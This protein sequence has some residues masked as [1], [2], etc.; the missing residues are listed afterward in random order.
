MA[1][2]RSKV[3]QNLPKNLYAA[4][5]KGVIYYT[6]KSPVDGKR[7][8]F[9]TDRQLAIAAANEINQHYSTAAA[10]VTRVM[11]SDTGIGDYIDHYKI[12]ILPK[13]RIKGQPLSRV[14]LDTYGWRL[15]LIKKALGS[16]SFKNTP[17]RVIAE[18]LNKQ[19]TAEVYNKHRSQLVLL[20]RHAVSDGIVPENYPEK[21][22]KR[23][24]E[25]KLRQRLTLDGYKAIYG[26]AKPSI[27][28][29][30]EIGLNFLHRRAD[31]QS[32]RF[33]DLKD[34]NIFRIVTKS[35]KHGSR[36]HLKIPADMPAIHSERGSTTLKGLIQS[37]RD[38]VLCPYLVHEKPKRY[39][40]SKEKAHHFQLSKS[41][42]SDGFAKARDGSGF[43]DD[44]PIDQRPTLHEVISLGEYLMKEAGWSLKFIQTLRGHANE[45]TTLSYLE[46]HDKW[47]ELALPEAEK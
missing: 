15:D 33:D 17:Q 8:G 45:A 44:M 41:Q 31:I 14:T 11:T 1:R 39:R 21:I 46:G 20:Y 27:Q 18:Y 34:G 36:A 28:S 4:I 13:R 26:H 5:T 37:C 3:N 35:E 47:T 40:P 24:N 43:Y 22:I 6:Y 19:A 7:K 42:L 38:D 12:N 2:P 16:R 30:M 25:P 10:L 23:D 29:A 9:G 32:F